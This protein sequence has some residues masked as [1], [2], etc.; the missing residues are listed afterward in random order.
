M[1]KSL[2]N[3]ALLKNRD[4]ILIGCAQGV[5]DIGNWFYTIAISATIYTYTKSAIAL[6]LVMILSLIPSALFSIVGGG[7]SDRYN[8]KRLM[9][10]TDV[11]RGLVTLFALLVTSAQYIYILYIITLI[12]SI[13]GAFFTTSRYSVITKI[14]PS[15]DISN[16]F[17]K[18]RILYELTVIL[19]SATGGIVFAFLGFKYIVYS[20]SLTFFI[21]LIFVLLIKYKED[22]KKDKERNNFIEMQ[23]EGFNYIKKSVKLRILSLYKVF[24][25]ISGGILN[26][27]PSILAIKIYNYGETGIGFIFSVI[28]FGSI[29]GAYIVGKLKDENFNKRNL[30][31]GGIVIISGW[32]FLLLSR[33]FYLA[34]V[35]VGIICMGNIFSHTY[36]ESYSVKDIEQQF[37][38]RIAGVFQSITYSAVLISLTLLA[39]LLDYNYQLTIIICI[40]LIIIPN[41]LMNLKK[42]KVIK[43]SNDMIEKEY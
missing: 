19:G 3:N 5:S 4:F 26:I 21:S 14:L 32:I 20:N 31:Y 39:K 13:C 41:S 38:G 6:S 24:Y 25:T 42:I 36:I 11:I 28:G 17:S 18:L 12:N 9:I 33:N 43:T 30:L 10:C 34:L 37:V 16:A 40:I 35:S 27:L 1:I 22:N 7:I 23:K 8:A 2:T 15:K 29:V